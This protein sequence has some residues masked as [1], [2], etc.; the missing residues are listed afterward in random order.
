PLLDAGGQKER[1]VRVLGLVDDHPLS[2]RGWMEKWGLLAELRASLLRE[3][4]REQYRSLWEEGKTDDLE[5]V[6][7]EVLSE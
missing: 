7:T 2:A 5:E 4:G 6:A 3:L 1:A